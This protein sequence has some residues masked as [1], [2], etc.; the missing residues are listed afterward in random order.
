VVGEHER[1][2]AHV[3]VV[4]ACPTVARGG[5]ATHVRGLPAAASPAAVEMAGGG[6]LRAQ[7]RVAK[8]LT[9]VAWPGVASCGGNGGRLRA[10]FAGHGGSVRAARS[11]VERV[12]ASE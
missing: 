4:A 7:S 6:V 12:R 10:S 11:G 8:A 1:A 5:S 9:V 3:L 2:H